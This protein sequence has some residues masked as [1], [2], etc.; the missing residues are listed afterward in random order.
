MTSLFAFDNA[1]LWSATR[2]GQV[3]VTATGGH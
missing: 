1:T 3:L 2:E